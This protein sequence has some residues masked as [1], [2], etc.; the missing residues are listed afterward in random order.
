MRTIGSCVIREVVELGGG[1]CVEGYP[2]ERAALGRSGDLRD[3][4]GCEFGADTVE[5]P[6]SLPLTTCF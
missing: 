2:A 5:S 4:A 6:S 3:T 1:E